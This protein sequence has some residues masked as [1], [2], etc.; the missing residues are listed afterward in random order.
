MILL[1][2]CKILGLDMAEVQRKSR[3]SVTTNA[4]AGQHTTSTETT[5]SK[6]QS[7]SS[8]RKL[9]RFLPNKSARS[10]KVSQKDLEESIELHVGG[11]DEHLGGRAA[12]GDSSM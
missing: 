12:G 3:R 6:R 2:K 9:S 11:E 10:K 1:I 8:L 5:G 7:F 4:H